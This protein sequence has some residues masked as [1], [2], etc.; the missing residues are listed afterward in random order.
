MRRYT[1]TLLFFGLLAMVACRRDQYSP[2]ITQYDEDQIKAYMS[3]NSLTGFTRDTSGIYYQLI[4]PGRDTALQYTS[5]VSMVF[6]VKSV[7]GKYS[8]LDTISNHYDG[9]LGH[10]STTTSPLGLDVVGLQQ[11][12]HNIVKRNGAIARIIVPSKLAYG[13]SGAGSG[14][15]SNTSGRIAGN[16][17]LD[18]YV[19]LIGDTVAQ[20][21]YDDMVIKNYINTNSLT[22]MQKD[23]AGYWYSITEAGPGTVPITY[24]STVIVTYTT[25]LLNGYIA[26]QYNSANGTGFDIP[27]LIPGVQMGLKKYGRAGALMTF[28]F[29]SRLAY[30]KQ[31]T[32]IPPNSVVRYDVRVLSVSP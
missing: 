5:N 25:T 7:D 6:T 10:I 15:I 28:L 18:Y 29:P 14:S 21:A 17:S 13:V 12:I 11:A 9:Y 19:H 2:T 27:D 24:Q 22:S 4:N 26:S 23:P 3:S 30:G 8:S 16:Q 1:Y 20:E 32:S 31:T